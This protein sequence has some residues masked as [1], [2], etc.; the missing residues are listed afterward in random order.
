MS[1]N[2]QVTIPESVRRKLKLKA[3]TEFVVFGGGDAIMLKTIQAPATNDFDSIAARLRR[4]ARRAG[5]KRSDVRRA[6]QKVR[7]RS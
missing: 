5:L 1:S 4:Y 2:G 3:G 7:G 6:I